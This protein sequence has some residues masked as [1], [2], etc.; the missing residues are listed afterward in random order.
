ML[1]A[2]IV[3]AAAH[4]QGK[5]QRI[6]FLSGGSPGPLHWTTRLHA[7]LQRIGYV[8]GKNLAIEARF[9]EN[10]IDRLPGFADE[11]ASGVSRMANKKNI[12][13]PV[14]RSR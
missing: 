13:A 4:Q 7:E 8:E 1:L 5:I 12:T 10:K 11:L 6:G 9:T 3:P 2:I 14:G